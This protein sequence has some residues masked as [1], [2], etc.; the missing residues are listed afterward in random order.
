L[1]EKEE[2]KEKSFVNRGF[3]GYEQPTY[4]ALIDPNLKDFFNTKSNK[5][6][7]RK[8]KLVSREGYIL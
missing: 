4:N 1:L 6:L 2:A 5:Q 3:S 7:L 8:M